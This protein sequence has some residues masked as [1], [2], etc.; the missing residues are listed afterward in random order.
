MPDREDRNMRH[1]CLQCRYVNVLGL[2]QAR[3]TWTHLAL[4]LCV[5]TC[6]GLANVSKHANPQHAPSLVSEWHGTTAGGRG[7]CCTEGQEDGAKQ[8]ELYGACSKTV[9]IGNFGAV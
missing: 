7:V 9:G 6:L 1:A 4:L 2:A 5:A 8:I 3:L